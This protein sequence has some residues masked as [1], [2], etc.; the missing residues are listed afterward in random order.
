MVAPKTAGPT[1]KP[2]NALA[3]HRDQ[4]RAILRR[5]DLINPR[6]VEARPLDEPRRVGRS[7]PVPHAAPGD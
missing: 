6:P 3:D 2:T 7:R 5:F 1:V 4:V